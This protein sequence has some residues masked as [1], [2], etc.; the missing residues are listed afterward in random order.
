MFALL[1]M[2][3]AFADDPLLGHIDEEAIHWSD[4]DGVGD[5]YVN[6]TCP[7]AS[8]GCVRQ[9]QQDVFAQ[10]LGIQLSERALEDAGLPVTETFVDARIADVATSFKL[11][12]VDALRVKVEED[13][14][15]WEVY[16]RSMRDT[17]VEARMT[18]FL[19]LS[20][21]QPEAWMGWAME[22][23]GVELNR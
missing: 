4:L 10:W 22:R 16:R 23:Y 12:T 9:T 14:M 17:L 21:I 8:P 18:Q 20:G 2:T 5:M 11:E 7:Y 15:P 1:F 13:G 19:Q 3:P 6:K